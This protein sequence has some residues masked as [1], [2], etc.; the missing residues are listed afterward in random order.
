MAGI[1]EQAGQKMSPEEIKQVKD[2]YKIGRTLAYQDQVFDGLV[3]DAQQNPTSALA[4]GIVNI[5]H[6]VQ[7]QV[8]QL[9]LSSAAALG[10]T[11]MDDIADALEQ[12]GMMENS[13]EIQLAAFQEATHMWLRSNQYSDDEVKGALADAGGDPSM[14]EQGGQQ[15]SGRQPPA[16]QPS[17]QQPGLIQGAM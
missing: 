5:L 1:I 7:E 17:Q 4:T 15:G 6:R 10:M 16:Q 8:G 14:L 12:S 2:G 13:P 11:L 9:K 3:K